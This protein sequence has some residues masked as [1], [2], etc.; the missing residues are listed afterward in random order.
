MLSPFF[1]CSSSSPSPAHAQWR[2]RHANAMVPLSPHRGS[3]ALLGDHTYLAPPRTPKLHFLSFAVPLH[4]L[5]MRSYRCRSSTASPGS[6]EGRGGGRHGMKGGRGRKAEGFLFGSCCWVGVWGV[7]CVWC[8]LAWCTLV[9]LA[10]PA[11]VVGG[12]LRHIQHSSFLSP[13]A[14]WRLQVPKDP[15]ETQACA[16]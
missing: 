3:T 15:A 2:A 13:Q 11:R 4:T 16:P 7:L 6:S 10:A 14:W 1:S 8:S 5:S 12:G 9:E